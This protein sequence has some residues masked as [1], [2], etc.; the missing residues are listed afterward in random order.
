[1]KAD[2]DKA[3]LKY[4]GL[5]ELN[6]P[7]IEQQLAASVGALSQHYFHGARGGMDLIALLGDVLRGRSPG[8][9][10]PTS[11]SLKRAR[12][13]TKDMTDTEARKYLDDL[14]DGKNPDEEDEDDEEEEKKGDKKK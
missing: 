14:I 13:A 5:I 3:L 8:A 2:P 12:D 11:K 4:K 9:G 10:T 7:F 1:M 6:S